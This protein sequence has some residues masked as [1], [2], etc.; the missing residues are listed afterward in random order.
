M[1][2]LDPPGVGARSL[3]EC[4][5]LQLA[6]GGEFTE[7]NI[8][9]IRFGLPLLAEGDYAGLAKLLG[10]SPA[11]ARRAGDVVRALNPIPSRGFCDRRG[12]ALIAPEAVIRRAGDGLVIEMNEGAV[13]RVSLNREYCNLVGDPG[14]QEA[15]LYLKEKLAEAK[16]LMNNMESRH[17]TLF[18]LLCALVREQEGYFL[19]REDLLPMT[20]EQM[21]QRL[22]LN[23]STISRA[24]KD[25]YVQFDGR[26]FPL[27]KL[28]STALPT[29]GSAEAARSRLRRFVEAEDPDRPLSDEALAQAL[30]G[31]GFSLSRRTVA[32]YRGELSIPPASQRRKRT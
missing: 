24:V 8:H 26:I 11:E 17:E 1:Q 27:R 23:V 3:S 2:A 32:K 16:N 31:V 5:L 10:V 22:N 9:M 29:G 6:Q 28:F 30:S 14:C 7:V 4:L 18:R 19:R 21:A 15:Q 12:T 20:M 13:P 25:K